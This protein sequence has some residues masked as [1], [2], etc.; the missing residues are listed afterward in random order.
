LRV[1]D[2]GLGL[3][4][5]PVQ[6][7]GIGLRVMQFRASLIGGGLTVQRLPEGG[8]SVVCAIRVEDAEQ[9]G[10]AATGGENDRMDRMT[11]PV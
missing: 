7:A 6:T 2:N 10:E 5:M 3:P 4:A 8:T 11:I 9:K 1:K